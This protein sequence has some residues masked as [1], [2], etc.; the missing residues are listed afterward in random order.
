MLKSTVTKMAIMFTHNW[1]LLSANTIS[2]CFM[3][4]ISPIL[5]NIQISNIISWYKLTENTGF[6]WHDQ[7]YSGEIDR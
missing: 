4:K 2:K 1:E 3:L 6:G 5:N 7:F